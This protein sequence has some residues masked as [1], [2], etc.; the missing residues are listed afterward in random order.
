MTAIAQSR[1]GLSRNAG[2]AGGSFIVTGGASGIGR[3]VALLL[4]DAGARVTIGD[5]DESGM[6]ETARLA[7]GFAGAIVAVSAD[8]TEESDVAALV[9]AAIAAHGRL[10]GAA[11]VA[12]FPPRQ[13]LLADITWEEWRECVD[14]NLGGAFL[15]M[16][17]Q[18]AEMVSSGRG[19]AIV[20]TS[21]NTAIAGFPLMSDY[22]SAKSGA[23]GLARV[24]VQEYG[25]KGIRINTVLPG[26]VETPMLRRLLDNSPEVEGPMIASGPPDRIGQP[27]EIA[28]AVRWLLSAEASYVNGACLAVDGGMTTG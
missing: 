27:D 26:P 6:D 28:Y 10:D 12:G 4:A 21:S 1:Y 18:I 24:A 17:Y 16:K 5:I 11:N 22:A 9:A 3:S 2:I 8:I 7:A 20:N 14:V 25:L 19:G 23:I 13:R 15:C